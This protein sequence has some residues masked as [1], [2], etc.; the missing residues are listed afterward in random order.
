[1]GY[2]TGTT[3]GEATSISADILME[4]EVDLAD[5]SMRSLFQSRLQGSLWKITQRF[6]TPT[7]LGYGIDAAYQASDKHE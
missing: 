5:Q 6:S 7:Y 3:E 2:I 4:D 1:F